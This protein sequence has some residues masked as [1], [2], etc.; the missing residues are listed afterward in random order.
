[1]PCCHANYNALQ[2]TFKRRL[3]RRLS[4]DAFY[5]WSHTLDQGQ[6]TFGT[7]SWQDQNDIAAEYGN[8]DLDVRQNFTFDYVYQLPDAPKIP[9]VIGSGWQ[10]SGITQWRSGVPYTITC[11][12]CTAMTGDGTMRP[13]YV[14]GVPVLTGNNGHTGLPVLNSA[15]FTLPSGYANYGDLGRNTMHGPGAINFDISASKRFRVTE[16]HS[17]QFRADFL[18]AFN[19]ANWGNPDS[20]LSDGGNFGTDHNVTTGRV[21]QLIGRYDF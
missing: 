20:N 11:G 1:M 18:N 21:I 14:A 9:K 12:A 3:S 2:L 5:T 13:D 10:V 19:H 7:S 6:A 17:I 8:S 4:F 16:R 15:A